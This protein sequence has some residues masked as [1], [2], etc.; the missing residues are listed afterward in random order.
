MTTTLDADVATY[1]DLIDRI[2]GLEDQL[3][4]VKARLAERPIGTHDTA[5]GVK[6]VISAPSRKFD[7]ELAWNMLNAEQRAATVGPIAAKVKAQL[8]AVLVDA[9]MQPGT[10]APIVKVV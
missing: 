9:C 1:L 4:T 8:P 10:G 3:A 6:V 2:K 5:H 7:V